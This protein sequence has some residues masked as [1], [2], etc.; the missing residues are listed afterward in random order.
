MDLTCSSA[1]RAGILII[2]EM[3]NKCPVVVKTQ[4]MVKE[5]DQSYA[6][7][8]AF[9]Y[10]IRHLVKTWFANC[11]FQCIEIPK[12]QYYIMKMLMF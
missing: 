6:H 5:V 4:E 9:R 12:S 8:L 7:K 1:G 3:L 11:P 2:I 10:K